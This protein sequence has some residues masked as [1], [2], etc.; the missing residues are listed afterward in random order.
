ML[1]RAATILI[2]VIYPVAVFVTLKFFSVTALAYVT[3]TVGAIRILLTI[4][5]RNR[6]HVRFD[7]L[8]GLLI[9]IGIAILWSGSASTARLYPVIVNIG[10]LAFFGWSLMHPPSA[11]ERIARITE[12]N[13]PDQAVAYTWRVTLVWCLFFLI[14][15]SVAFYTAFWSSLEVWTIYNG[16]ISYIAMGLL[17]AVEYLIRRRVRSAYETTDV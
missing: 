5:P 11:V 6:P 14:N 9:I 17:F 13:L 2:T 3:L 16:L 15:G 1:D 7:E 10:M 12:P 4:T 8:G